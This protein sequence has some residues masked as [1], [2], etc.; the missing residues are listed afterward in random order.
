MATFVEYR[1]TILVPISNEN[2][3][4]LDEQFVKIMNMTQEELLEYVIDI[5]YTDIVDR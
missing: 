3:E 2:D 5:E 1:A 4:V